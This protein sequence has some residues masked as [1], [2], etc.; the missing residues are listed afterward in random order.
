M[1]NIIVDYSDHNDYNHCDCKDL[2]AISNLYA[3][4]HQVNMRLIEQNL[5]QSTTTSKALHLLGSL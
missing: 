2:Q 4:K 3:T 5:Q 1:E